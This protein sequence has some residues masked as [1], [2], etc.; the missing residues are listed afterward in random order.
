MCD[1]EGS[2]RHFSFERAS[3]RLEASSTQ[4]RCAL[5]TGK[6]GKKKKNPKPKPKPSHCWGEQKRS[7]LKEKAGMDREQSLNFNFSKALFLNSQKSKI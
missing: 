2:S 1:G 5:S 6:Q 7:S 4:G 3:S